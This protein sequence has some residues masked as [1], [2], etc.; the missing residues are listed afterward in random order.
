[1][2]RVGEFWSSLWP[3]H[4]KVMRQPL[5]PRGFAVSTLWG[6]ACLEAAL[7]AAA[8]QAAPNRVHVCKL[9]EGGGRKSAAS[10]KK[11][12][13]DRGICWHMLGPC[14]M[15]VLHTDTWH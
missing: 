7:E 5:W 11:I 4:A 12:L 14:N 2:E 15:Q 9:R 1:M 3:V 10:G 8:S 6:K 13:G